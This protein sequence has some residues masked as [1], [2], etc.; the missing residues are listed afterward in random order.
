MCAVIQSLLI[1]LKL[2]HEAALFLLND[3]TNLLK[4]TSSTTMIIKLY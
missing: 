3:K 2:N 1:H 4:E